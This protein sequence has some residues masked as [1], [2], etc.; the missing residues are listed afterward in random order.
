MCSDAAALLRAE[1]LLRQR[2]EQR[3]LGVAIADH[4]RI[5]DVF[6][7][8]V[9]AIAVLAHHFFGLPQLLVVGAQ[10]FVG[11]AQDR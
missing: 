1:Q 9:Q 11:A 4:D 3:D 6:D 5:A 10:L 8:Q 2:I 7:D